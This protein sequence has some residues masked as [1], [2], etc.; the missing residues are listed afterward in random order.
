[1]EDRGQAAGRAMWIAGLLAL[2]FVP[3][4]ALSRFATEVGARDLEIPTIRAW[5]DPA[6]TLLSPLLTWAEPDVVYQTLGKAWVFLLAP[7]LLTAIAAYRRRQ[8]RGGERL[9]WWIALVGYGFLTCS[10]VGDFWTP[11]TMASFTLLTIPGFLVSLLGSTLLGIFL[12]RRAFY[13]RA[14]AWMLALAI[15]G[16]VAGTFTVAFAGGLLFLM[17][18]WAVAGRSMWLG[19][20]MAT[21]SP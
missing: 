17:W 8:P 21:A 16:F 12:V 1:M 20:E 5:A 19:Q 10:T 13:P 2:A 4:Y 14:T 6:G 18:A 15:P 11:W 9:A 3:L 7:M